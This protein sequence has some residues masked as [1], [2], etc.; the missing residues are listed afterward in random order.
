MTVLK[1][2][3]WFFEQK[4]N[5]THWENQQKWEIHITRD[6]CFPGRKHVTSD[7]TR[8]TEKINKNEKYISLGICVS[9]GENM[10]PVIHLYV[11]LGR[12]THITTNMCWRVEK[13]IPLGICVAR[14]GNVHISL[15]ICL[16][17][18]E[19]HI[20]LGIYVPQVGQ[21]ISLGICVS[22]VG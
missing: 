15:E 5:Q 3:S 16:S 20:S 21:H 14:K 7:A 13:H 1:I 8:H 9:Q 4:S 2:A 22:Q 19:E 18:E 11:F 12:K 17:Q 10:S 6:M